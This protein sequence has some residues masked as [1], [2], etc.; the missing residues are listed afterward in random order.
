MESIFEDDDNDGDDF[1]S[2]EL[3]DDEELDDLDDLDDL[4]FGSD[5]EE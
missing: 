5:D 3:F 4:D 2:A 1:A